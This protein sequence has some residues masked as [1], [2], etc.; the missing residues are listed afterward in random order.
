ADVL[1]IIATQASNVPALRCGKKCSFRRHS[2]PVPTSI[3]RGS[4]KRHARPPLKGGLAICNGVRFEAIVVVTI[5]FTLI[6]LDPL[7]VTEPGDTV[8]SAPEGAP[9]QLRVTGWLSPPT[10]ARLSR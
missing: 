9:A 8:Q 10:A 4:S 3:N 2:Q 6:A 1:R 5:T 7:G